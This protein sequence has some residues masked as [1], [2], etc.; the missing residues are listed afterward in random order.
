[1]N[2][3]NAQKGVKNEGGLQLDEFFSLEIRLAG[4]AI[5]GTKNDRIKA[6]GIRYLGIFAMTKWAFHF[7]LKGVALYF[8][9]SNL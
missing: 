8:F 9:Y 2:G 1:L 5:A 7:L 3:E 4:P 6:P